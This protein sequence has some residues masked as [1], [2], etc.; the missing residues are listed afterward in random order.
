MWRTTP[1]SPFLVEC[2]LLVLCFKF[3]R[4]WT[5]NGR[6][7]K[8]FVKFKMVAAAILDL[9]KCVRYCLKPLQPSAMYLYIKFRQNRTTNGRV[10]QDFVKFKMAAAAIL[11]VAQTSAFTKFQ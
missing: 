3:H 8:D 6:V 1:L 11:D 10:M 2:V 7:I 5:V 9:Y 4:N